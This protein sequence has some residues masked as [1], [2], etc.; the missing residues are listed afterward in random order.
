MTLVHSFSSVAEVVFER[1][2][3]QFSEES[4]V[5]TVCVHVYT[6]SVDCPINFPFSVM[7]SSIDSSAG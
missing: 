4:E 7:L 1:T 2:Y 6:P 3:Y 5:N